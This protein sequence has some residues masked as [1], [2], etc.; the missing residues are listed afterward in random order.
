[1]YDGCVV[2]CINININLERT[3]VT[4]MGREGVLL[5]TV[6]DWKLENKLNQLN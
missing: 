4:L 3:E 1:L 2:T 5:V 6:Q